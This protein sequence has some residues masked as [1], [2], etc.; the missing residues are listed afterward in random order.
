MKWINYAKKC[1]AVVFFLMTSFQLLYIPFSS[2]I[3]SH[4]LYIGAYNHIGIKRIV[5]NRKVCFNVSSSQAY[6]HIYFL[7]FQFKSFNFFTITLLG[8]YWAVSPCN[9]SY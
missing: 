8:L 1:A 9:Y 2:F 5:I 3:C 7:F 4:L 6:I